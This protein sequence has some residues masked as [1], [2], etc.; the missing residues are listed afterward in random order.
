[1]LSKS[2]YRAAAATILGAAYLWLSLEKRVVFC[3]DKYLTWVRCK[4]ANGFLA[5][6]SVHFPHDCYFEAGPSRYGNVS[7]RRA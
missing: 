4:A 2:D 7:R 3:A 1:M 6:T 5:L